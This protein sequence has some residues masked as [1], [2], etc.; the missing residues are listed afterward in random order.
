MVPKRRKRAPRRIEISEEH[1]R[2]MRAWVLWMIQQC[3]QGR[4]V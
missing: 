4:E 3:A 1:M 2:H